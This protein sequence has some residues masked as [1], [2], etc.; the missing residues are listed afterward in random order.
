MARTKA[1]YTA[2]KALNTPDSIPEGMEKVSI[3]RYLERAKRDKAGNITEGQDRKHTFRI[4][5]PVE[6][7]TSGAGIINWQKIQV[8]NG[9]DGNI[10]SARAI[11]S[12]AIDTYFAE[13][14]KAD[15]NKA[16]L[17]T[18]DLVLDFSSPRVTDEAEAAGSALT[19][20]LKANPGKVP[21]QDV[22]D[23]IFAGVA[24]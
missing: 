11:R 15:E 7:P 3:T 5:L 13:V 22:L 23:Q 4:L 20:W 18:G 12:A 10:L 17:P 21:T 1:E 19:D 2:P 9:Q 14:K 24:K 8:E 16:E 6:G